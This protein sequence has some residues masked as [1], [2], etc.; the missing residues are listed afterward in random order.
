M[1]RFLVLD[2]SEVSHYLRIVGSLNFRSYNHLVAC[3]PIA[4]GS[5]ILLKLA[6]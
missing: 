6:T 3:L 4:G 2:K 1:Q 5:L